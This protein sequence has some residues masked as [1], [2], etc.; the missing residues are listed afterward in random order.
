MRRALYRL[1]Q[2][3]YH[4]W[5][6]PLGPDERAEVQCCLNPALAAL[7]GRQ[8]VGEQV[9]SLRVMR[10]LA[11]G[12]GAST[13]P[14]LLQ[15]ALLHDVGK[16]LSPL[17]LFD[18]GLV[19]LARALAPAAIRGWGQGQARGWRRPFVTAE[20]HPEWGAELC[21]RAGA[22]PLTVTLIRRHA[23]PRHGSPVTRPA[24][25]PETPEDTLLALLQ[26][27]DDDN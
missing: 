3:R 20:R 12:G 2:F 27:A 21:A 17:S 6:R 8:T 9:H 18:R 5:P 1:A 4:R 13:R 15:A 7:F 10:A 24:M 22:S 19:V 26:A 16:S 23:S 14:E 11:A 25:K